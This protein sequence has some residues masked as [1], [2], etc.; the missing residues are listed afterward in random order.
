VFCTSLFVLL[1]FFFGYI[2]L[3]VRLGFAAFDYPLDIFKLFIGEY[4]LCLRPYFIILRHKY[5]YRKLTLNVD[6]L[7]RI[8]NNVMLVSLNE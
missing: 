4:S 6:I 3:S 1:S 5:T 8:N 7:Q 2:A